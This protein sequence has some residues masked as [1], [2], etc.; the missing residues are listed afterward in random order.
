M[1]SANFQAMGRGKAP[2]LTEGIIR[3]VYTNMNVIFLFLVP[4]IT[5]RLIAEEKKL[6]TIELL[7][8]SPIG[9]GELVW[10]KFLSSL[11][12]VLC[13]LGCTL[14]YPAILF[15]LGNPEWGPILT[16][17][18]GVILLFSC[19]LAM[20]L[21][22]SAVTENQIV[23]G[24]LTFAGGL[25]FWL[26]IWASNALSGVWSEVFTYLSLTHHFTSFS[27]G[28]LDTNDIFF[29]CAFTGLGLFFT[30]RILDSYRWR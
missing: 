5:M 30:H 3:P 12:F 15:A 25:F 21:M 27:Q 1:Q 9:L 23:A 24:V 7:M 28:V 19:Y 8:T 22:F 6:H 18:L 26:I 14:V 17:Y 4:F 29:Y 11:L 10:G 2:S 20:G 13:M 16:C